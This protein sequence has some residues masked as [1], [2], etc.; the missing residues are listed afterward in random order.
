MLSQGVFTFHISHF[1]F[2]ISHF[3]FH[4]SHFT[5]HIS[6]FTFHISH[7]TFHIS[8]FTFHIFTFHISHFTF[9]ISH[10]TFHISHF[11]ISHF[12]FH[13][14]GRISLRTDDGKIL[15][16][17]VSRRHQHQ[18]TA[19]AQSGSTYLTRFVGCE[20]IVVR[21]MPISSGSVFDNCRQLDVTDFNFRVPSGQTSRAKRIRFLYPAKLW[22][23]HGR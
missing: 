14:S 19:P 1:T 15:G 5:F 12:T 9:H 20:L 21:G 6:H 18:A 17:S 23:H 11:H 8:H 3:T 22:E 7:F 10:F 2:H 16:A 4:I 13:I